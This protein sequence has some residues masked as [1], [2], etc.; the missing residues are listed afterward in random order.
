[1]TSSVGSTV[2]YSSAKNTTNP[3]TLASAVPWASCSGWAQVLIMPT[4]LAWKE[5]VT[6]QYHKFCHGQLTCKFLVLWWLR[7]NSQLFGNIC[8]KTSESSVYI[9]ATEILDFYRIY[10]ICLIFIELLRVVLSPGWWIKDNIP[11]SLICL[12]LGQVA[13]TPEPSHVSLLYR[14]MPASW[15]TSPGVPGWALHKHAD[16]TRESSPSESLPSS[17]LFS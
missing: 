4:S 3:A 16:S 13:I 11:R 5:T 14:S 15:V 1:M 7:F 2:L 12:H 17:W 9:K 6:R 10:I 8:G